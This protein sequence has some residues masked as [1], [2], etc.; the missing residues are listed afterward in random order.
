M[1]FLRLGFGLEMVLAADYAWNI[2]LPVG[3]GFA[4]DVWLWAWGLLLCCIPMWG[5]YAFRP[6]WADALCRIFQ[7]VYALV[8]VLLTTYYVFQHQPLDHILF[9]YSA[10]DLKSTV[11]SSVRWDVKTI[12]FP[13]LTFALSV[14]GICRFSG[15]LHFRTALIFLVLSILPCTVSPSRVLDKETAYASR[16]HYLLGVNQVAYTCHRCAQ[17]LFSPKEIQVSEADMLSAIHRY[18]RLYPERN[19]LSSKYP[20]MR[21][22]TDEDV[23][24]AF[25]E[26]TSDGIPPNLV[27]LIIEGWGQELSASH[28]SSVSFTP[29]LDSLKTGALYWENCLST[30]ER[31]FGVLPALLASAP[32]GDKGFCNSYEPVPVHASLLKD[33]KK[34]GYYTAFFYGGSAAFDGQD[35]FLRAN[36]LS[37]IAQPSYASGKN[38][39]QMKEHHRWGLDDGEM[40][41]MAE[42][43]RQKFPQFSQGKRRPLAEV[44]LTLS[45]HEPFEISGMEAYLQRVDILSE[46]ISD[47]DER[48]RVRKH[49]NIFACYLYMDDC[50]RAWWKRYEKSPA[51]RQTVF[52]I[53]GDHRMA[54]LGSGNPLQKYHVPLMVVSPLL[55]ESRQMQAV[56]SHWDVVP[57]LNAYLSAHYAYS[58]PSFCAWVGQSLD[59]ASDFCCHHHLAF[60]LNNR[61]VVDYL[62]DAMCVSQGRLFRVLPNLQVE[63]CTDMSRYEELM[64]ELNDYRK[65]STYAVGHNRLFNEAESVHLLNVQRREKPSTV[66]ATE[67]F[68]SLVDYVT[69]PSDYNSLELELDFCMKPQSGKLPSLVLEVEDL[70]Y[71][72]TDLNQEKNV[73]TKE[74]DNAYSIRLS[75]PLDG[76]GKGKLMKLYFW[77]PEQ[78]VAE[79]A[80]INMKLYAR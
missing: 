20:F 45:T 70:Y 17:Y 73:Q 33:L 53:T 39:Q 1:L 14:W 75:I 18:R 78:A 72:K 48:V 3:M 68:V 43:Q 11:L 74:G 40:F 42:K 37:Y 12:V 62:S 38:T 6:R 50:V 26:K 59:T 30:A 66:S 47:P 54:L 67:K 10:V 27:F 22:T 28:P 49:R 51:F 80:H 41:E 64:Q 19:Y 7:C 8:A 55:K 44:Y 63:L 61:D 60:M 24:G 4:M 35:L 31:T 2:F 46:R 15:K 16:D 25:L 79:Y 36:E 32:L 5:L 21:Q 76:R 9:A 56:V 23:L 57:T 13:L 69:L 65:I 71:L 58:V 52:V 77:N 34:N 29:F